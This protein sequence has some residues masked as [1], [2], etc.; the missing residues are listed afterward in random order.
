MVTSLMFQNSSGT[1]FHGSVN[2]DGEA[3]VAWIRMVDE[4]PEA[5]S[6][7]NGKGYWISTLTI[8][9]QNLCGADAHRVKRTVHGS[10]MAI[11]VLLELDPEL[12][13]A[14]VGPAGHGSTP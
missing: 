10:E 9:K 7:L 8:T 2:Q 6:P 5:V 12:R 13:T 14:F 1:E 3:G 11:G 4:V